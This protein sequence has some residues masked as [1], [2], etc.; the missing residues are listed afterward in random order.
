MLYRGPYST[1][2][3]R[4]LHRVV[5]K[6]F[7]L[8]KAAVT[9][10]PVRHV[11]NAARSV[12][13]REQLGLARDAVTLPLDEFVLHRMERR[14]QRD[15]PVRDAPDLVTIADAFSSTAARYDAFGEDHPH[16]TRMRGKVYA[17]VERHVT[18]GTRVLE[19][20]AGTGTDAIQL[21]QRGYR[22]HA[23][24]IAPGMLARIR[25]K[26]V[27]RGFEDTVTVQDCS[28]LELE[29]VTG[30]PYDAVLSNLGGLNCVADLDAVA[31]GLDRVLAP[32]GT[33]VLVVMPP[34][35]LWELA[36]VFTGD[37]RLATRR[38]SRGGTVCTSRR[39]RV[40]GALL[41]TATATTRARAW[42]RAAL[43]G[44]A[45]G[46]HAHRGVEAARQTASGPVRAPCLARRPVG[47]ARALPRVG[48]LL[49]RRRPP[50]RERGGMS[51]SYPV[52]KGKHALDAVVTPAEMVAHRQRGGRLPASV[53]F[54]A[55][56]ICLQR[57]LPERLRRQT[58]IRRVGHLMGDLYS[59]NATRGRVAVLTNLGLGAPMVASQ[60]DELL[61][62]GVRRLVSIALSGGIQP[63]LAPGAVVV[64]DGAI[65]DE[66]TS[67]HYLPP[68]REV[69]PDA[70]L[71]AALTSALSGQGRDVHVGR[72]WS[73]DAPY[74]ETRDEVVRYQAEGVLT[75]DM[76]LA[77]LLAVAEACGA[78]AAGVLVVGDSLADG[79]WRPP[80]RLDG[81]ERSLERAYRAAIKVLD[82]A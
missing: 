35:C 65:R 1:E 3:Y 9:R 30:A 11:A 45:V 48:R 38:L 81:M 15:E 32:G 33:A 10:T 55:A 40:H 2:F 17:T 13:S 66:G 62:L 24:D 73:T 57:G 6:E 37:F 47:A 4:Q 75:V 74:R 79:V 53:S 5:H 68:G 49:R 34:I 69:A 67:H 46:V 78:A 76:E 29:R 71:Q 19:L 23:T 58:R 36:L 70:A 14:E 56:V 18:P 60:A 21:A 63:D 39:P 64:A 77:A 61:A 59:V 16:L 54:D 7:R 44:R 41:H 31:K 20:N 72:T 12:T 8:R 25:D 27:A 52:F 28:F 42:L 43:R 51:S 80:D 22:V 50:R 82:G 26:V